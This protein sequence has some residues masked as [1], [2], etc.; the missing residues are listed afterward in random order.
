ML[1]F[2]RYLA[3]SLAAT[4]LLIAAACGGGDSVPDDLKDVCTQS[5]N[6]ATDT[7]Q[8]TSPESGDDAASPLSVSGTV[9]VQGEI[10]FLTIVDSGGE[11]IASYPAR[12]NQTGTPVPFQQ[13][14]PFGV[15]EET[16]ACL[17]VSHRNEPDPQD[18]IRIPIT[19][20]PGGTPRRT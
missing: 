16:P 6:A 20:L 4:A 11:R 19:L 8:I 1:C 9:T 7:I 18:A 10:L 2:V 5:D 3:L 12:P 14:V 17:W 13:D 15:E